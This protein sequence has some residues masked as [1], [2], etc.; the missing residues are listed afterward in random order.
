MKYVLAI[1]SFKGC[2]TS[3]EAEMAVAMGIQQ[4]D[5]Q[6]EVV[7]VPVSDGGEGMLEAFVSALGGSVVQARVHDPLMRPVNAAYGISA[8]GSTAIIEMAKSSGLTLLGEEE[9]NPMMTTTYGTGELIADAMRKGCRRMI[10]G[11]GGSATSDAGM[12]MLQALGMEFHD[13]YGRLLL[14]EGRS[15]LKMASI[16]TNH[17][18]KDL[19]ACEF[20]IASDVT[21]PLFGPQGAAPVFGPQK[22]ASPEEVT[23][24]DAAMKNFAELA[25][26][27]HEAHLPG[28]GAAGGLGFALLA[29]TRARSMSG[30]KLLLNLVDFPSLVQ[31]ARCVITG[32][33]SA[34]AQTLM[35]K[36]PH[37]I[38]EQARE[39]GV[40]VW[41]LAG[42]V[43]QR[44][45]LLR[46]GF[47]YVECINPPEIPLSEAMNPEVAKANLR[48]TVISI[49]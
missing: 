20:V 18:S 47:S 38:L 49:L 22:G 34:D 3:Q 44:E 4:A 14:P 46:A 35:G 23:L 45:E 2:L 5:P 43:Q 7:K 12:G 11:L 41:L 29:F 26:K 8:D 33:G 16:N 28:S 37:G 40:P 32:E 21:N 42:K 48:H 15:L 39:A 6:A 30:I 24:L 10:V 27:L 1:D 31:G 19:S 25:R 13:A 9:R 36:L 17:L